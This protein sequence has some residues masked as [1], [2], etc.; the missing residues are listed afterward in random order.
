MQGSRSSSSCSNASAM[1]FPLAVAL[2]YLD[3]IAKTWL[4]IG[5]KLHESIYGNAN[6]SNDDISRPMTQAKTPSKDPS[7]KWQ[8]HGNILEFSLGD[9][10]R[11]K[12]HDP[13]GNSSSSSPSK[14]G[15]SEDPSEVAGEVHHPSSNG[16]VLTPST[17]TEGATSN[18]SATSNRSWSCCLRLARRPKVL[19]LSS[20]PRATDKTLV[21]DLDETLIHARKHSSLGDGRFDFMVVLP[22]RTL[23]GIGIC[24]GRA[25]SPSTSPS[26]PRRF[27]GRKGKAVG[28]WTRRNGLIGGFTSSLFGLSKGSRAHGRSGAAA[29]GGGERRVYVRKRPHLR[30]FLQAVSSQFEIVVF[31]AAREDFA[32]KVLQ[33]IDPNREMVDHVLSR[34][35]CTRLRLSRKSPSFVKDLGIIGRPLSKVRTSFLA[36]VVLLA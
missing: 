28:G 23:G 15:L 36:D 20:R 14:V 16:Q 17:S 10:L 25:G 4:A 7:Y 2:A 21:L 3:A 35:S 22:P 6:S 34:E 29:S 18:F 5:E 13:L 26:V 32:M 30:H 24:S 9:F 11:W 19:P 8:H 1:I 12:M 27:S 33:E 31:T